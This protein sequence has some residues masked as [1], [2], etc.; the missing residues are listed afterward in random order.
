MLALCFTLGYMLQLID[1][2]GFIVA[3]FANTMPP[4]LIPIIG[5]LVSLLIGYATGSRQR[6]RCHAASGHASGARYGS[7]PRAGVCR[8]VFRQSVGRSGSPISDVLIENSGAN[9]VDPVILSKCM[10]PY[11][12]IDL[13][14]SLAAF[15]I[16]S[17]VL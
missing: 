1:F 10:M 8:G 13:G 15:T 4:V 5:F 11:R 17:F 7:Q 2:S 9:E 3:S 14:I 12:W 16:L 6:A